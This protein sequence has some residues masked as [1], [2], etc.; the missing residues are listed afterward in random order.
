MKEKI[1]TLDRLLSLHDR[2]TY[3]QAIRKI[4]EAEPELGS[5]TSDQRPLPLRA[6]VRDEDNGATYEFEELTDLTK[7]RNLL[8]SLIDELG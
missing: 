2:K 7:E 5:S 4:R 1:Y 6:I 3:E 8:R